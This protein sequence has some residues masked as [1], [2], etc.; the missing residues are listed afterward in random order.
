MYAQRPPQIVD[1]E[2]REINEIYTTRISVF[3]IQTKY[4]GNGNV[5]QKRWRFRQICLTPSNY[6]N[7][8]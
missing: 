2:N 7:I 3:R 6:Y 5:F 4:T 1:D 8:K